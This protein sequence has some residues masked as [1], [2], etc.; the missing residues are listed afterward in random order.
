MRTIVP[1]PR[2]PDEVFW[3]VCSL[4]RDFGGWPRAGEI[5]TLFLLRGL[6]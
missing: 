5:P 4:W 3:L 1:I 2:V 6:P